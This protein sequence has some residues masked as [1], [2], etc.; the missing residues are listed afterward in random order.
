MQ[1]DSHPPALLLKQA[2]MPLL[3]DPELLDLSSRERQIRH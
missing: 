2:R 3:H 1:W